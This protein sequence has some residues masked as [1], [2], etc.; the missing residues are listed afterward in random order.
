MASV[1]TKN[2]MQERQKE[3]KGRKEYERIAIASALSSS[4][5]Q[6]PQ[7]A[8]PTVDG[9]DTM[10]KPRRFSIIDVDGISFFFLSGGQIFSLDWRCAREEEEEEKRP[11]TKKKLT[12]SFSFSLVPAQC[13][14]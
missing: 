2:E 7:T 13:P 3:M 14:V 11:K 5:L 9:Q 4:T 8:V 6:V 1:K 10:T 12:F